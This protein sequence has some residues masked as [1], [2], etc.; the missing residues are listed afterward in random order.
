MNWIS[1][2]KKQLKSFKQRTELA[3]RIVRLQNQNGGLA[4]GS[5]ITL[6]IGVMFGSIVLVKVT[7][8]LQDMLSGATGLGNVGI[9]ISAIPLV[10]GVGIF[11]MI[12]KEVIE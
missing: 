7:P 9:L 6:V 3:V 2:L 10:L 1:S 12:Y 4:I 11:Y 8:I 5:I